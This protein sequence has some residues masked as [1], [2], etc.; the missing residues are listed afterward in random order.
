MERPSWI[1]RQL[2]SGVF[3][4]D[5]LIMKRDHV[6]EFSDDPQCILRIQLM[7]SHH[8]ITLG[9]QQV[10]KGDTVLVV[11]VWNERIP[12]IPPGG[13]DLA[14]ALK[15]RRQVIYSFKLLAK[16]VGEKPIYDTVVALYGDSVLFSSNSHTGGLRLIQSL[17]FTV[18]PFHHP[19]GKFGVFW[20][21]LFSWWL[22]WA[23]SQ[24]SQD[25]RDF[26]HLERTEIW[27]SKFDFLRWYS[28]I[29]QKS[30]IQAEN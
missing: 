18:L 3:F 26:R 22:M 10:N 23:F 13:A 14:W 25:S 2:Q 19:L 6:Y 11:H 20:E 7:P 5:S 28:R 12:H 24:V 15:M 8:A 4:I 9:D 21:N 29:E 1:K 17:G 27:M 30:E 16:E